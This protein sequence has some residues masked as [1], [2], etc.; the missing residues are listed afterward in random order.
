MPRRKQV[1]K[2]THPNGK[3]YFGMD[4]TGSL[5]YFGSPSAIERIETDLAAHLL[6]LR[7]RKQIL[8]IRVSTD[9]TDAKPYYG[10]ASTDIPCK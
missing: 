8:A 1:Y 5:T 9:V 6:D 4:L 10:W 3:I 2:I 7:L